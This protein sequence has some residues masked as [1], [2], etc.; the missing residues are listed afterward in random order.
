MELWSQSIRSIQFASSFSFFIAVAVFLLLVTLAGIWRGR[1]KGNKGA[2]KLTEVS[3]I[4]K[5]GVSRE[6]FSKYARVLFVTLLTLSIALMWLQ[7]QIEVPAS[8]QDTSD[9]DIRYLFL[10]E[11]ISTSTIGKYSACPSVEG[12]PPELEDKQ[13]F[14]IHKD[15]TSRFIKNVPSDFRVAWYF[16][17]SKRVPYRQPTSSTNELA[18]S[19]ARHTLV[20]KS[21]SGE[22][23]SDLWRFSEG[24]RIREALLYTENM[25]NELG[26]E[27]KLESTA[28]ILITDLKYNGLLLTQTL[29]QLSERGV[30]VY[31]LTHVS[32]EDLQPD[33]EAFADNELVNFFTVVPEEAMDAAYQEVLKLEK[34]RTIV[35][36]D[37][38]TYKSIM[39]TVALWV[40][41][42]LVLGIVL[43]EQFAHRS[44]GGE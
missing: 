39:P 41:V 38:A 12:C 26:L 23:L 37:T 40:L 16:F 9:Q 4:G 35:E 18:R 11:D 17:S 30:R 42:F 14:E 27:E 15:A 34:S 22:N 25:I 1:R 29:T 33:I 24:T 5:F 28:I 10:V 43:L 2:V 7:P 36:Q 32:E 13:A 21:E 20:E 19:V 44:R 3:S 8:S 6:R 31:V